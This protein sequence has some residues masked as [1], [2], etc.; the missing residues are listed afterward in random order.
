MH[1]PLNHNPYCVV[2]E[3]SCKLRP[4]MSYS[5]QLAI[6]NHFP[7]NKYNSL[8]Y[9]EG[10]FPNFFNDIYC[11]KCNSA[12]PPIST[13][14]TGPP[15]VVNFSQPS[16]PGVYFQKQSFLNSHSP[17]SPVLSHSPTMPH[18]PVSESIPGVG[19]RIARPASQE[20]IPSDINHNPP[21]QFPK[22]S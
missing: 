20:T 12:P 18:A 3:S 16:S 7:S 10:P 22:G 13:T 4:G 1:Q 15:P 2:Y 17:L 8:H 5:S 9:G 14:L 6:P 11:S 21:S 19:P